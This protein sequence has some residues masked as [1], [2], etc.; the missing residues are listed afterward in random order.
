MVGQGKAD[1]KENGAGAG[2]TAGNQSGNQSGNASAAAG[3]GGQG[4]ASGQ[5]G[6]SG[7]GGLGASVTTGLFFGLWPALRA[8][9]VDLREALQGASKGAV[10]SSS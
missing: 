4:G 1:G 3:P 7:Q 9:R 8:A 10:G 5:A 6:A 2:Q